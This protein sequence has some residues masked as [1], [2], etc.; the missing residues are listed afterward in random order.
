V[1]SYPDCRDQEPALQYASSAVLDSAHDDDTR[2]GRRSGPPPRRGR[3]GKARRR[4]D[5]LWAK[6]LVIF[7]ALLMLASGSMIIGQKLIFAAATSSFNQTD[8]LDPAQP[9]QHVSINGAKNI[10]L[11]GVDSRPNQNPN[12]LVRADSI[13]VL[14]VP[15]SHDRA[16]LVSIPRDTYVQIPAYSNGK[17][18]YRGGSDKIN[19][20]FAW[21]GDGLTGLDGRKKGFILLQQT[22]KLNYHLDFQAGA[23]VDFE[24]FKDVVSVLGGVDMYIDEKTTSIHIGTNN[25][26]GKFQTPYSIDSNARPH[27]IAGVTPKVYDVGQKHLAPWEALDYVRQRDILANNDGDYGRARH[28]QQF[29][30]AIF[31]GILSNKVLT[32]PGKLKAVL[33][34]VGKAMTVDN[35]GINLDDWIFAMRNISS[36]SIITIKTNGGQFNSRSV[37]GLGD[38]EEMSQTSLQLM[39][40]VRTDTID[41]FIQAHTDWVSQSQS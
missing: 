15:A 31:K 12:D 5:P 29:I 14:H 10:L 41:E 19:S 24:G 25:R 7:G 37:P 16:Y 6:L 18:T 9:K 13:M 1:A 38:V 28:Q 3:T 22:I 34:V 21:G 40:H 26:T 2:R 8:L 36:S 27:P 32:D 11:V 33:D 30:K 23:I 17:K 39:E 35:G 20:A 4:R